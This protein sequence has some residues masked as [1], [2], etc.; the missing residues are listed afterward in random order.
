MERLYMKYWYAFF[1]SYSLLQPTIDQPRIYVIF[2]IF[3]SKLNC[4]LASK[5][6]QNKDWMKLVKLNKAECG[7]INS[8]NLS[9]YFRLRVSLTGWFLE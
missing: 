8:E 6:V 3:G 9:L 5:K 7:K 4:S 1:S 2:W